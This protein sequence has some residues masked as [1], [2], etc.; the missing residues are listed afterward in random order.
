MDAWAHPTPPR[1]P[2]VRPWITGNRWG[3]EVGH[4]IWAPDS[5]STKLTVSTGI[6]GEFA[7][8]PVERPSS[9]RL[10]MARYL[11][12]LV[13]DGGVHSPWHLEALCGWPDSGT[14]RVVVHAFRRPRHRSR[15][16]GF[17]MS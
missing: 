4:R 16:L 10:K 17:L 6:A 12:G 2:Q 9:A 8:N 15:R 1:S 14:D 7:A 13:S 5:S 11:L 3:I